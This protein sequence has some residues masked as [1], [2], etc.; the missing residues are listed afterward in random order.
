[1]S[2]YNFKNFFKTT[3]PIHNKEYVSNGIFLI[4]KSVLKKSHLTYINSFPEQE[5]K[6][7]SILPMLEK[8]QNRDIISDFNPEYFIPGNEYDILT[9]G[10]NAIQEKYYNFISDIKGKITTTYDESKKPLSIYHWENGQYIFVGILLPLNNSSIDKS[11]AI[12]YSERLEQ[13]KQD[14]EQKENNKS[15]LMKPL[16]INGMYNREGKRIRAN[17]LKTIGK[18]P[19]WVTN[20]K[21]DKDY[22]KN[23]NDKYYLHIQVNDWLI[24]IGFTEYELKQRAGYEYLNK[25]WYG[26]FEGRQKYFDEHFY[27]GRTYEEYSDLVKEHI[28]KEEA[29]IEENGNNDT[30]QAEFISQL[31]DKA[32]KNYINARDNGG[33]FADFIGALFLNELDKCDEIAKVLKVERQEKELERKKVIAE[34]KAKEAEEKEQAEKILIE[35]TENI[36]INGGTIKGGEIIVKLANKYKINVPLR[37]KGWILKSLAESIITPDGGVSYRYWKNKG[38]KGSQTVYNVLHNIRSAI[39]NS[40]VANITDK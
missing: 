38:A 35:E 24:M 7:K 17:Y 20:G 2:N 32:I 21:P 39:N 18:Y 16:F 40:I 6:I 30:I 8:E 4:K 3:R 5:E 31:V 15:K 27:N 37:T 1:M 25:E 36:F 11:N 13:L 10:F 33:K 29:F 23:E 19:L 28:Q 14:K 26:D 22:T 9:S 34:Q 12:P